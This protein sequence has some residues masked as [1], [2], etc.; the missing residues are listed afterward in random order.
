MDAR[1]RLNQV[2]S[3]PAADPAAVALA[4]TTFHHRELDAPTQLLRID[5]L[6]DVVRTTDRRGDT[7]APPVGQA[8]VVTRLQDV[9]GDHLGYR[10]DPAQPRTSADAHLHL[11]LD[12]HR[13]LP[14][15]LSVLYAAVAR[16][17]EVPAFVINLPGHVVVGIGE[18]R[19]V[20]VLDAYAGGAALGEAAMTALVAQATS[21]R[22][23]FTRSMVRPAT[24]PELARRI[25]ANLT[26]D[27]TKEEH[28][29]AALWTVVAR[30]VM[31]D[32]DPRDHLVLA[33][34]LE[35]SGRFVRAAQAYDRYLETVPDAADRPEVE[36][37]ARAA[38]S[39]TN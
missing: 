15:T 2:V 38:R 34:L 8:E 14:V 36:A 35:R 4:V 3:N 9:L 1:K 7:A 12:T 37:R 16:R 22:S 17:L 21:G 6:A 10:G 26:V 23:R 13:G 32:P 25:L 19:D 18:G 28:P 29:G 5:A 20:A 24:P 30:L 27:I 39:R 33:S 31:P 11:T